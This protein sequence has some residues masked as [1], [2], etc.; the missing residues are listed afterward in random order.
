MNF[1]KKI[2][3]GLAA[4]QNGYCTDCTGDE[5][6]PTAGYMATIKAALDPLGIMNPG[7]VLKAH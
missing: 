4:G 5:S 1:T 2:A 3:A 6:K 7:A